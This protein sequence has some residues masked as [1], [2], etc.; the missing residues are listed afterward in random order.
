M[1]QHLKATVVLPLLVGV[2]MLPL[3]AFNPPGGG[4]RG[5]GQPQGGGQQPG[6]GPVPVED[7]CA[8]Y[9]CAAAYDEIIRI[10]WDKY[11]ALQDSI[12]AVQLLI[13][14]ECDEPDADEA[15]CNAAEIDKDI[16]IDRFLEI[17]A[18]YWRLRDEYEECCGQWP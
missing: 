10:Y 14:L 15:A 16:A 1:S 4:Q 8:D 11:N 5:G 12:A 7:P 3:F 13:D 6:G 9:D 2:L 18:E 17:D